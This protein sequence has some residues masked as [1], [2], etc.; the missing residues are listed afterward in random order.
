MNVR[1]MVD[2]HFK[3]NA[4]ATVACIP[5]A[6]AEA[7]SFGI[8]QTDEEG[9]ITGFQEKPERNPITMPGRSHPLPGLHGQL[10]LHPGPLAEALYSDAKAESHHDFGRNFCP[11]W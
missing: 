9:R 10:H 4:V 8:V 2:F 1:Q 11:T 5:I 7:S 6:V 3:R